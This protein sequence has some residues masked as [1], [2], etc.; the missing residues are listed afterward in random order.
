M[1]IRILFLKLARILSLLNL[2]AYPLNTNCN[3]EWQTVILASHSGLQLIF[4][5][6]NILT[7]NWKNIGN[8]EEK[9]FVNL[10]ESWSWELYTFSI[11][12]DW[13]NPRSFRITICTA[14]NLWHILKT[15]PQHFQCSSYFL[16]NI[17]NI[18]PIF[19]ARGQM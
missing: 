5:S 7:D 13:L 8:V 17:S 19:T 14:I 3:P 4:K 11:L 12:S 16:F 9:I 2:M 1:F 18:L 15:N 6:D 10:S